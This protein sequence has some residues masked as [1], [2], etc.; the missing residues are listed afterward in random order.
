MKILIFDM[1]FSVSGHRI[2][3][4]A[5]AAEAFADC[6]VVVAFPKQIQGESVLGNYFSD[7]VS[8]QFFDAQPK[9]KALEIVRESWRCL[10]RQIRHTRPDTVVVPT[11][12][13]M[14]FWGGIKNLIGLAGTG[15]VPI[16][17]SLMKGHFR[18]P[19]D[20]WLKKTV[21]NIKW[22]VVTKGPWRKILLID[23]RSFEDL[24][25]PASRN[26][27]LCPDPA[28]PQKFF[29]RVEARQALELPIRGQLLVSV[30]NQEERK[31][32]DLL[33][34]AFEQLK[35][36]TSATLLMIGKFSDEVK[37]M[38]EQVSSLCK[39][40]NKIVIRDEYVSDDQLQQAVVA[41]DVVAVPYRDVERPSGIVSRAVAWGRPLLATDGG[42]LKWFVIKYKAGHL[43][44]PQDP[45]QFGQDIKRALEA[46]L[47]FKPSAES[48]EFSIFNS[49]AMYRDIW[50]LAPN[51]PTVEHK[52][53]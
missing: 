49:A 14:A 51:N 38:A 1:C 52:E 22:W 13:G 11:G 46:S 9:V 29:D 16:D 39:G 32:S 19:S 34:K 31:G 30:G 2:P 20:S 8:F 25:N 4:A 6:E 47:K 35:G 48:T 40:E 28:P 37:N 43:T 17:V 5:L 41:S 27:I 10:V 50:R 53:K 24:K 44:N 45:Q 23:P 15:G 3:Y 21:S 12:D 26:V 33:L 7:Q 18:S 42:W 36:D